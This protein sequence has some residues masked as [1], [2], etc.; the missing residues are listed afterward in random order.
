[1]L[2]LVIW[3]VCLVVTLQDFSQEVQGCRVKI[4]VQPTSE[5]HWL[6]NEGDEA[7][8][9][10]RGRICDT[11]KTILNDSGILFKINNQILHLLTF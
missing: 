6:Q 9:D 4:M 5:Q 1:M 3:E 8:Q 10:C 11:G 7:M 2:P